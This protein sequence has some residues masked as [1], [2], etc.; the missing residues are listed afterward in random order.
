VPLATNQ[1]LGRAGWR[2]GLGQYPGD[3]FHRD[4]ARSKTTADD[5]AVDVDVLM[6]NNNNGR[7]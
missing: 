2:G 3:D 4:N 6:F 5:N 1:L 7:N